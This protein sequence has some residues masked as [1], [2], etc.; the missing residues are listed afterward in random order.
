MRSL[1]IKKV[2]FSFIVSF[3][4]K[5][6]ISMNSGKKSLKDFG[7]SF[8]E[9]GQ[10]KNIITNEPFVF[11]VYNG[12]RKK[13]QQHYEQLGEI[14]DEHI[15]K[16][17]EEDTKLIKVII[18]LDCSNNE[19]CSFIFQSEDAM[20]AEKV[21][22]L[23]HGSGVVRAGQWS[24]RLIINHSLEAGSQLPYIKKGAELGFGI[25]VLNSNYNYDQNTKTSIR[26]SETPNDHFDYV[27]K[28]IISRSNAK[29]VAIV[30]HSYGGVITVEGAL[31]NPE[32]VDKTFVVALTD[33]VHH[34]SP[35]DNRLNLWMKTNVRNW[36]SSNA[37]LDK[38]LSYRDIDCPRYS[39][40]TPVH[41]ET[42]WKAFDSVWNFIESK[43]ED[44]INNKRTIQQKEE[45]D[46]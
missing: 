14:I 28:Q 27:W 9:A 39:A 32:M 40:G 33:S 41:E 43:W 31:N 1:N 11:D 8:N 3:F 2:N 45:K 30:A 22:L 25:F 36:V 13:N 37:E 26:G 23:I 5:G 6:I 24:R 12:N 44:R 34:L 29:H 7:Y 19:G 18:P 10:L 42:S 15:Y 35:Q 4:I 38:V 20:S 16:L 21:L 17:L 46:L